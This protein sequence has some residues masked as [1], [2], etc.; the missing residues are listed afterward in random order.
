MKKIHLI[1]IR[2]YFFDDLQKEL[3]QTIDYANGAGLARVIPKNLM[4]QKIKNYIR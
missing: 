3:I 4:R 1:I 2:Q